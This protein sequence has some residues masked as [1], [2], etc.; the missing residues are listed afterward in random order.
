VH[1]AVYAA[2]QEAAAVAGVRSPYAAAMGFQ[3]RDLA[4]VD[5]ESSEELG[6]VPVLTLGLDELMDAAPEAVAKALTEAP[7]CILAGQGV[8]A[9]GAH[10]RQAMQ[11]AALVEHAARILVL[12]RQ[13]SV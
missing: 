12:A 8:Y 7:A 2:R 11:R 10:P 13:V 9:W 3:G 5:L 6:V 1:G 4:P